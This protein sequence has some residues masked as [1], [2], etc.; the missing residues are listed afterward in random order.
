MYLSRHRS[1][2]KKINN[3]VDTAARRLRRYYRKRIIFYIT[4][5]TFSFLYPTIW[6]G[7]GS[8]SSTI[9][10]T[11]TN[12]WH[13]NYNI[14]LIYYFYYILLYARRA[15]NHIRED[16]RVVTCAPSYTLTRDYANTILYYIFSLRLSAIK[17]GLESK[18]T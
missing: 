6:P 17:V 13:F 5:T 18:V 15:R 12:D 9:G 1:S 11:D 16:G 14:K 10:V 2:E 3:Y 8:P 7:V 4:K